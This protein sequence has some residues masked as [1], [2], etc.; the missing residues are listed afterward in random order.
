[1]STS[2][3]PAKMFNFFFFLNLNFT[4]FLQGICQMSA[5]SE[6]GSS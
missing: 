4:F 2:A 3:S 5:Q 1:M 6:R